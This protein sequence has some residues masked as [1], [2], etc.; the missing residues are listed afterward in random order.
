M[1]VACA[2]A[3]KNYAAACIYYAWRGAGS[4]LGITRAETVP[5]PLQLRPAKCL[6]HPSGL[7]RSAVPGDFARL[8]ACS[9]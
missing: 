5:V 3:R 9:G 7:L 2:D 6:Q 8:C 1:L 4:R